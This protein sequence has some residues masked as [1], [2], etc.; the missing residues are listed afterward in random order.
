[1]RRIQETANSHL[2]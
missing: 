1:M 2:G